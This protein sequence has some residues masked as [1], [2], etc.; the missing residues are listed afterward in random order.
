MLLGVIE[1]LIDFKSPLK[2][3]PTPNKKEQCYIVLF[4][5]VSCFS[6]FILSLKLMISIVSHGKITIYSRRLHY[7]IVN[8]FRYH[9]AH[10]HF[11]FLT[12]TWATP[13]TSSA[14]SS[15]LHILK[16]HLPSRTHSNASSPM[17]RPPH[18]KMSHPLLNSHSTS[19]MPFL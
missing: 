2:T 17:K 7:N 11:P 9:M 10:T 8:L 13:C 14:F 18:Q 5:V 15:H 1:K 12:F 16:P 4:Q 3:K 6:F 19:C